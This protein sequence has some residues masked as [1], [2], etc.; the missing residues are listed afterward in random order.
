[1]N[2][3]IAFIWENYEFGGTTTNL[4]SLINSKKFRKKKII[5]F[6]NST[7][8]A[9]KKFRKLIKN[10]R[11][12]IITF[13]NYLDLK[14]KKTLNKIF[15][16][17]FR[18]FVFFFTLIKLFKL[19]KKFEIDIFVSQCGGYG[20]FRSDLGSILIAKILNFRLK[21]IVFHHSYSK[22][23]LWSF[24]SNLINSIFLNFSDKFI[25]VSKA[26]YRNL[27]TKTFFNFK[28]KDFKILSNGIEIDKININAKIKK[29]INKKFINGIVLAR[30]SED[31]GHEDLIKAC[32]LLPSKL[33]KKIR[34]YFVGEGNKKY[35]SYLKS[36]IK[37][38]DTN[39][40]FY[41]SGY[42]KGSSREIINHFDFLVSPS[43]YFE[44]FGLSI[45]EALSVGTPVIS[46]KVGGV[47]D[48]LNKKNSILV[49]PFDIKK[50]CDALIIVCQNRKDLLKKKSNGIR[51]IKN[52]YTNDVMGEKYLNY[53]NKTIYD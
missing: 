51:L 27:S 44:G 4:A 41:F 3:T 19:L 20:D 10:S 52:K 53:L 14:F 45:A 6:T 50:I 49:K 30:I 23:R 9:L 37:K 17:L 38:N 42:V 36:I 34:I 1:M 2:Q 29:L 39:K 5:I 31:K 11:V 46:T 24:S 25:F 48:Y 22:P 26:T 16:L 32:S 18:P 21:V 15:L 43:R 7:N 47:T 12:R 35:V 8:Q 13:D 40:I 33:K 28:N